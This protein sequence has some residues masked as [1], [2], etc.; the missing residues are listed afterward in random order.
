MADPIRCTDGC[1]A[2]VKDES[3]AQAKAWQYMEISK[4]YRCPQCRRDL[5]QVNELN[6]MYGIDTKL[7]TA[8]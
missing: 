5:Q 2:N 6:K 3:E 8:I 1:G 4:R 7:R